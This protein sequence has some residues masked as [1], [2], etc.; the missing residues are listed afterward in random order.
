MN[1]KYISVDA[2]EDVVI[3]SPELTCRSCRHSGSYMSE[4]DGLVDLFCQKDATPHPT[5]C[6][7]FESENANDA[8]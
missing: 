8:D 7:S 6:G 4:E 2:I 3:E 1:K 5:V